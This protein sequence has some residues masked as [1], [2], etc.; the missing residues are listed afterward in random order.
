MATTAIGTLLPILKDAGDAHTRFGT[1]LLALGAVGEFGP[2]LLIT[3]VLSST[4]PAHEAVILIAFVAVAVLTGL[5]GVRSTPR[6]WPL[7]ERTFETSSQ[8]AV[9]LAV[10][11]IF[12]LVALASDLGLDLLLGGFLAGLITR[13]ALHGRELEVFESKLT[14]IGYGFLIPFFFITSGMKFDLD[15]LARSP[16]PPVRRRSG[17]ACAPFRPPAA[18]AC[19]ADGSRTPRTKMRP[20]GFRSSTAGRRRRRPSSDLATRRAAAVISSSTGG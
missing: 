17:S 11:L 19:G 12:A 18:C 9:R 16:R 7:L 14:A 5:L 3:L 13:Q 4:H 2:I 1:Y 6:G 15:A 8:L 10:I 20:A